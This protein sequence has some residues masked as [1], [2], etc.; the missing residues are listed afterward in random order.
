MTPNVTIR[1]QRAVPTW[2]QRRRNLR[3]SN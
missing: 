1:K 3:T 2:M